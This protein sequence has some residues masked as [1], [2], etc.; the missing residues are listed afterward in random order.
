MFQ[1]SFHSHP[2]VSIGNGQIRVTVTVTGGHIAEITNLTT[3]VN[4]LWVPPWADEPDA[5]FGA[6]T[7]SRLLAT[8]MG[9]NLCL[10]LF[11]PPSDAE[12]A[13][14]IAAHGE[15]A[16][17]DYSFTEIEN[18]FELQSELPASQLAFKRSL[19]L[20]GRRVVIRE[21][22]ENL[23]PWDRPIAWT[24]HVTLGPPFL[25]P[26]VT[27]F[28]FASTESESWGDPYT[29]YLMDPSQEEASFHAWSPT[30]KTGFGYSWKRA[31]FPWMGI[32]RENRG[33]THTPW[34]GRTVTQGMEFG[35]SPFP[36]TRRAMIERGTLF[37]TPCYRWIGGRQTLTAEYSAGFTE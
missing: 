6:N 33:R 11:G 32:W 27:E 13:A 26:G 18:G 30:L 23:S 19:V 36:E 4:P 15:A 21:T 34:L 29:A 20:Q 25:E 8:I 2:A 14:G 10:D 9:H 7:E 17:V 35:V 31:D 5:D 22:V 3:G 37:G 24:Q 1:T 28:R 12:A 16:L